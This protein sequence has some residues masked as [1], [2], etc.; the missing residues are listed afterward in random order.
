MSLL[1]Q[2]ANKPRNEHMSAGL[3]LRADIARRG[4]HGGKVPEASHPRR[5]RPSTGF[6][7]DVFKTGHLSKQLVTV[8]ATAWIRSRA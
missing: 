5:D 4:W 3:P 1:G 6:F 8:A 2:N 7:A